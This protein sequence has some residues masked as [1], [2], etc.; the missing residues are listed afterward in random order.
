MAVLQWKQSHH[1]FR[2]LHKLLDAFMFRRVIQYGWLMRIPINSRG[3]CIRIRT[4]IAKQLA[5]AVVGYLLAVPRT[6]R[7][8]VIELSQ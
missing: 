8:N 5:I 7:M 3:I 4:Q 1:F 2:I 6:S